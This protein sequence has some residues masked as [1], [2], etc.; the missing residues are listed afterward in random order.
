M[1]SSARRAGW[2]TECEPIWR[3]S[4]VE[5]YLERRWWPGPRP[6]ETSRREGRSGLSKPRPSRAS[7]LPETHG[8]QSLGQGHC[9]RSC[10]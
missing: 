9:R 6:L 3:R 4:T 2:A 7:S 8:E 5:P 10:P 1:L